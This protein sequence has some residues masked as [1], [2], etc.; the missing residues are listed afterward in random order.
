MLYDAMVDDLMDEMVEME[1]HRDPPQP[2][3]TIRYGPWFGAHVFAPV[4]ETMCNPVAARE[5]HPEAKT[6]GTDHH[7]FK[8]GWEQAQTM[9]IGRRCNI[10]MGSHTQ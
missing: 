5:A 9:T 6:V 1:F 7:Y 8:G 2:W 4:S 10:S 3:R